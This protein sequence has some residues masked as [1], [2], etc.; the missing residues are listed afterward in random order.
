MK[1]L[2]AVD[3]SD[4]SITKTNLSTMDQTRKQSKLEFNA[5]PATLIGA[6]GKGWDVLSTV[7]D[8]AA[9]GLA[10]EQVGGAQKVLEM[11]VEYAKVRVQF[12]RPIGSFQAVKHRLVESAC[13]LSRDAARAPAEGAP[14]SAARAATAQAYRAEAF[15]TVA[16]ETI[17]PHGGIGF[18]WEHEAHLSF[19]RAHGSA[20]L[21]GTP[22]WHR[23]R[24]ARTVLPA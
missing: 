16:G 11:A 5:T 15:H 2:L 8:L 21:F 7:L 17:Q 9:V 4:S 13:S 1:V 22:G 19:K 6:E 24:L 12:G 3:G 14:D 10:A 23:G 18:T 20:Q